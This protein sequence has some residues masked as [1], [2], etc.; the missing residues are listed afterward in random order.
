[1]KEKFI[2][3]S[4][5]AMLDILDEIIKD[6]NYHKDYDTIESLYEEIHILWLEK[7]EKYLSKPKAKEKLQLIDNYIKDLDIKYDNLF[8]LVNYF[9]PI[10]IEYNEA[11]HKAEVNELR[12]INRE[13]K[14]KI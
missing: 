4:L 10:R 11:I 9:D 6:N 13:K 3:K 12:R 7:K 8:D 5:K 2:K 14:G 1:M